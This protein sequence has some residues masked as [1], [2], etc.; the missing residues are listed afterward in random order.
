MD[1]IGSDP[2]SCLIINQ[3]TELDSPVYPALDPT[4]ISCEPSELLPCA[5]FKPM[6]NYEFISGGTGDTL[7]SINTAQRLHFSV[8]AP[9]PASALTIP[10]N[11]ISSQDCNGIVG[12]FVPVPC[13]P[14]FPFFL[15]YLNGQNPLLFES[16]DNAIS[17]GQ[18]GRWDNFH[19]TDLSSVAPP[20]PVPPGCPECVHIHWRWSNVFGAAWQSGQPLIPAGSNQSVNFAIVRYR[21]GEE[22]PTNYTDLIGSPLGETLNGFPIVF[23]YSAT[24]YQ[25]FDSFFTHGGFFSPSAPGP[26]SLRASITQSRVGSALTVNLTLSNAGP[27]VA[28]QVLVNQVLS[29]ILAGNGTLTYTGPPLPAVVGDILPG[30][31]MSLSLTFSMVSTVSRV[32]LSEGVSFKDDFGQIENTSF[33]QVVFP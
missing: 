3:Q 29:R 16:G 6:V 4:T 5:K 18:P 2:N 24:G 30:A 22:N 25:A 33:S 32:S 11:S 8:N 17:N 31:S 7:T 13:N 19:Q 21:A 26:A 27:G 9:D 1:N 23:W 15:S 10:A 14:V 28:H 20:V 12:S